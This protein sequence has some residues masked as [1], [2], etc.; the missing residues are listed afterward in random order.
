MPMAAPQV[1]P[2][3]HA[4][5][6]KLDRRLAA[7]LECLRGL[8]LDPAL[9]H[10]EHDCGVGV[11]TELL[12]VVGC[13]SDTDQY[14]VEERH[15]RAGRPGHSKPPACAT[16]R[17]CGSRNERVFPSDAA[18]PASRLRNAAGSRAFRTRRTRPYHH[19][20]SCEHFPLA[21]RATERRTMPGAPLLTQPDPKEVDHG[22]VVVKSS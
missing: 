4:M 21:W 15:N 13:D 17:G 19:S 22:P 10:P 3:K 8:H 12:R 6:L 14:R 20:F 7:L 1:K 11:A 2:E 5:N 9:L 16:C 18:A